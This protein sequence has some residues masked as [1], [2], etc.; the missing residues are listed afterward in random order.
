[1]IITCSNRNTASSRSLFAM[2]ASC[3]N[4]AILSPFSV[5]CTFV[6]PNDL[7]ISAMISP[8]CAVISPV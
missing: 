4:C 8:V 7:L 2:W 1:M 5:V 3:S 6:P